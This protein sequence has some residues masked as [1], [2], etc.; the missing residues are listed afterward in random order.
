MSSVHAP[1]RP[2]LCVTALG[3]RFRGRAPVLDGADIAI[4]SDS[5]LLL[6]GGNGTGKSTLL[7]ILAGLEPADRGVFDTGSG[8]RTWR[9]A[10]QQLLA[11]CVYVHQQPYM[12]DGSV[13]R[14]VAF[15]VRRLPRAI[16]NPMTAE[17]LEWAGLEDL[18]EQPA[19][20]LSGGE[21]QRVALA[22][23]WL[24][25]P[26]I[27]LLDEPT[28]NLD[29]Q[30]RVRALQLLTR[31]REQGTALVIATH[32]PGHWISFQADS[33]CLSAGALEPAPIELSD[34]ITPLDPGRH[35]KVGPA[36][37]G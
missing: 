23:A 16:R 1:P 33:L 21:R 22:R 29:D 3:K 5:C 28:A 9:R 30:A 13:R 8:P 18:A 17:A 15:A 11:L 14:N 26:S 27:M 25:R 7:K 34:Q 20:T 31:L 19:T 36:R 32:D 6:R 12:L 4:G 2:L 35:H 24:R 37:H 10:R